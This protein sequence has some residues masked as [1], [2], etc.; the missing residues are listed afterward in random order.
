M[1]LLHQNLLNTGPLEDL[2]TWTDE[3]DKEDTR[4]AMGK[5]RKDKETNQEK[6]KTKGEAIKKLKLKCK[7][8]IFGRSI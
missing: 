5:G 7:Y 3:K 6:E 4:G 1:T 8:F 2:N